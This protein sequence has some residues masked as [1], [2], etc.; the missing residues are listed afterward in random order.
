ML[1]GVWAD[2]LPRHKVMVATD[3]IRFSAH[4]L[5]AV[6]ISPAPSRSGTSS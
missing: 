4:A 5:L 6:L 3:L 2:R 1:G